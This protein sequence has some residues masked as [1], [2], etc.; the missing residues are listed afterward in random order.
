M[1]I[2]LRLKLALISLLLLAIPLTGIRLAAIVKTNLLESKKETLMFS[3]RAVASA[4]SGRE[5]LFDRELFHSLDRNRDLYLFQLTSPMRLNGKT[6]DWQPHLENALHFGS[7]HI[8][9]SPENYDPKGSGFRHLVGRRESFLYAVFLVNDDHLVFR[10]ENSLALDRSDHLQIA[11]EDRQGNLNRY[12]VTAS[13]PGWVNGYLTSRDFDSILPAKNEPRIQ[14]VWETTPSGY[15]LEMRLPLEL[16]GNRL[17]FAIADVDDV[18]SRR[19]ETVIGTAGIDNPENIGWLLAPSTSIEKILESL[20]RPQSKIQ[21]IDSNQHIRASWGSLRSTDEEVDLYAHKSFLSVLNRFLSPLYHLFTEPFSTDFADPKA[22]PATLNL[23]GVREAL[24]GKSLTSS[25][26]LADGEVEVM[27]AIT[28]LYEND[29]IVGAVVV[30]QTTNSIL[31]LK[32]RVI[33]E[34]IGLTLLILVFG[35]C[36]LLFFAFRISSR[37]RLLRDQ[38]AAAIGENG[39]ILAIAPAA[40]ARDEIGDLSRT[41][42]SVL[43]QLKAQSLYREKMADNL[44]HEMRT[45]LAG[46]SASLKNLAQELSGQPEHITSYVNWALGDIKRMED[47]LTGIR[48]AANL[49][50]ALAQGFVEKFNISE[51]LSMWLNHSW[52][53]T[54]NQAAFIYN[55][56][57]HDIFLLGDPDRIRQM[58]DKLIENAVAFHHHGTA[59]ELRLKADKHT[60]R[61]DIV[62]QG[63]HIPENMLEEIFNSMVSVRTSSDNRPHL[64]LGLFVVRTIAHHHNG[65]VTAAN[66]HAETKGVCFTV[67]LPQPERIEI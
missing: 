24:L 64:G 39:Q 28:P 22:Q 41:L 33:E 6:D 36:G 67:E 1:R 11:I 65:S 13:K 45:P 14:G 27:T 8:L 48:D 29:T 59:V 46:I 58:L 66:F 3:A 15:I 32:N 47:M 63:P 10:P 25:Y 49:K 18:L 52:R 30:E 34:S 62:N 9:Q 4:L 43:S 40:K 44:E 5:G 35:G 55:K 31:A 17:A 38:A 61:I 19:I 60:F 7:E 56:P 16:V 53:T 2:S 50:T 20:N 26:R 12:I 23:E 42:H 51:A 21:I 54:F 37:I 57:P